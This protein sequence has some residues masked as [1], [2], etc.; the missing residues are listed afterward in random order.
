M[1]IGVLKAYDSANDITRY[2]HAISAVDATGKRNTFWVDTVCEQGEQPDIRAIEAA[3]A[4]EVEARGL[5]G[6]QRPEH[7]APVARDWSD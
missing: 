2:R 5:T 4:K 3:M 7:F 1:D 6:L